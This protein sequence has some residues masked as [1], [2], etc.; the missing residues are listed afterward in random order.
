MHAKGKNS[1]R[2]G[3]LGDDKIW[4]SPGH[5]IRRYNR[6]TPTNWANGIIGRI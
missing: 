6:A 1:K 2:V 4:M 5:D 3:C